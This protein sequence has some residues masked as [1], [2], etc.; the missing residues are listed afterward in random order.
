MEYKKYDIINYMARSC[1]NKTSME[2]HSY[3]LVGHYTTVLKN[4]FQRLGRGNTG[5]T[6]A[7]ELGVGFGSGTYAIASL[8]RDCR[9]IATELSTAMLIRQKKEGLKKFPECEKQILRCQINADELILKD[10]SF[11]LLFGPAILHHVFDPLSKL[12]NE[13][14]RP[15]RPNRIAIFC[16]PFEPGYALLKIKYEFLLFM[17]NS[18]RFPFKHTSLALQQ[19]N[20]LNDCIS[21]WNANRVDVRHSK[22]DF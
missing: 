22:E 12:I 21:T 3:N 18:K 10:N 6:N 4:A 16:E 7:L 2:N 8:L 17:E 19:R 11:D 9:R 1:S 20:Y 13:E 5:I 15:L 14:G